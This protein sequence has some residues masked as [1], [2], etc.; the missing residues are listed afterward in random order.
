M[1]PEQII[2]MTFEQVT[3]ETVA[4]LSGLR[5]NMLERMCATCNPA[6]GGDTD[7]NGVPIIPPVEV[8]GPKDESGNHVS[9]RRPRIRLRCTGCGY[10]VYSTR[11]MTALR[12]LTGMESLEGDKR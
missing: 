9:E 10:E 4:A 6:H 12:V 11:S 8:V 3:D 1:T 2:Q 5:L 7:E